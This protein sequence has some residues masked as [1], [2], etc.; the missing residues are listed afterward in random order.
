MPLAEK[1]ERDISGYKITAY[2]TWYEI[3]DAGGVVFIAPEE[4]G[5]ADPETNIQRAITWLRNLGRIKDTAQVDK[6][7][8]L[9]PTASTA[10][11]ADMIRM[12]DK[13][14]KQKRYSDENLVEFAPGQL[15]EEALEYTDGSSREEMIQAA[16]FLLLEIER[17]DLIEGR[18]VA[19]SPT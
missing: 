5:V 11:S 15:L 16:A 4:E 19:P 3:H 18:N 17:I 8:E 12:V 1:V 2:Q 13:M 9:M 7:A 10:A 14:R 6:I